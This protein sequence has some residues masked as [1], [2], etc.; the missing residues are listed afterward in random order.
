[1]ASFAV[2]ALF[3]GTEEVMAMYISIGQIVNT[4]GIKGEVKVKVFS[5]SLD[6]F[7]GVGQVFVASDEGGDDG[8]LLTISGLRYQKDMALMSFNEIGDMTEA[9]KLKNCFLQ[10]PESELPA[11]PD[12]RYYIY[13]LEG[14]AVWEG[15]VCYGTLTEVMQPGSNDVYVVSDG[16]REL[17][18]PALKTVIKSVDLEKCRM[19][20]EL[21]AGL[22]ELY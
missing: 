20:V 15:D 9:E 6:R 5:D 8:R 11:L 19:E 17:L 22:L 3:C 18:I 1:M 10:V 13:Q 7:E 16:K 2:P 12:G 21:P 4:H 14:I